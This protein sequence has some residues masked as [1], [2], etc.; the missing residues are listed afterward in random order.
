MLDILDKDENAVSLHIRRGDYLQPKHW[1]TT[2]SVCQL[3]YYQNAKMC[4]RDSS[5]TPQG[6]L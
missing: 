3:P 4:I 5:N 6:D 1:A 2:G